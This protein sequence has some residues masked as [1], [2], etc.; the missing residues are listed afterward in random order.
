MRA[1]MTLGLKVPLQKECLSTKQKAE[2]KVSIEGIAKS[3]SITFTLLL[4]C[5]YTSPGIT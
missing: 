3:T 2:E 5:W 1:A 4:L